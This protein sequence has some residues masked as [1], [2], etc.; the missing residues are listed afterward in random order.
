MTDRQLRAFKYFELELKSLSSFL[1]VSNPYLKSLT[2]SDFWE[3]EGIK[4]EKARISGLLTFSPTTSEFIARSFEKNI[5]FLS[6]ELLYIR[7]VSALEIFLVQTVRD[8]FKQTI[9]PFESNIKKI[10]LNHSQILQ[11]TS[12]R[13]LRNSMLHKETRP[14]SSAGYEDVVKYYKHQLKVDISSLGPGLGKMKYYHQI[15]HILVHRL[16]KVDKHFKKEYNFSKTYL[17]IDESLLISLF[18]DVYSYAFQVSEKIKILI[19][20]NKVLKIYRHFKG[21]RLRIEF[22]SQI[23][24]KVNFLEPE[25]HFW[26]GDDIFY[27]EDLGLNIISKGPHYIVEFWGEIE[28]VK[29]YKKS[30]KT[31]LKTSKYFANISIRPVAHPKVFDESIILAVSKVLPKGVWPLDIRKTI[32][33]ELGI[34][35]NKVSQI[36]KTLNSRGMH[37]KPE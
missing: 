13:Q 8:I 3:D 26:V 22:D 35:I 1:I 34:S 15:R 14:L 29:A 25:Y 19:N 16:G 12:I 5:S 23:N 21:E 17:Q 27:L 2:S 30:I 20:A 11:L 37:L 9:K 32:A 28:I 6:R 24:D 31:R 4:T 10:E 18:N 33:A 7:I 36:I